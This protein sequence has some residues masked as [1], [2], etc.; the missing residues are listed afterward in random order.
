MPTIRRKRL[1]IAIALVCGGVAGSV[2]ASGFRVPEASI[3]GL[4]LSNALVANPNETGALAYNPAAMAFHPG[5]TLVG[6]IILIDPTNEVTNSAGHTEANGKDTFVKPGLYYM[7][8]INS[9]WSWGINV[10][11]P[12]GLETQWPAGT[13][14]NYAALGAAAFE[15]AKSKVEMAN[16]NP[17][18]S[19][20]ISPNT[21]VAFGVDYYYVK[22]V[23]LNTQAL[24]I[25]GDGDAWGWNVAL[26]HRTGPVTLGLSYRSSV[27]TDIDGS[28]SGFGVSGSATTGVE[29]PAML[30]LGI[31]YQVNPQLAVEFDYDRTEWS[32][33]DALIISHTNPAP[34]PNPIINENNWRDSQAFRF[35]VVY[36]LDAVNQLRF[37]YSLDNTPQSAEYFSAR[38]PDNDRQLFSVGYA[39]D[40]G[41]WLLEAAYMYVTVDDRTIAEPIFAPTNG[42]S[43]GKYESD[44][45]LFG[46]GV[47]KSF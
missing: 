14:P 20:K 21:S 15:P 17:N 43:N 31:H 45:H 4:G 6:G 23:N 35:G 2:Q 7:D 10:G 19:Y 33:F 18:F 40:M 28:V 41:G 13:F 5:K 36:D 38:V 24:T 26:M 47:S 39:R 32:S 27:D 3:A 46:I 12:F 34:I 1:S 25:E 44:V 30:Q 16:I 42:L 9:Q 8:H 22:D 11:A 37:G 29:F